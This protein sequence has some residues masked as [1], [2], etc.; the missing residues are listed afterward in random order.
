MFRQFTS[1]E[2]I[3]EYLEHN[4]DA[5]DDANVEQAGEYVTSIFASPITDDPKVMMEVHRWFDLETNTDFGHVVRKHFDDLLE[6]DLNLYKFK[7]LT[8]YRGP[9]DREQFIDDMKD[10]AYSDN[11][12]E[13]VAKHKDFPQEVRDE[14]YKKTE[15]VDF[16][17]QIAQDV[18]IF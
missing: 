5:I 11:E 10:R 13:V 2:Q 16:L 6:T 9:L 15:D 17:P 12:L 8:S 1:K 4:K 3:F 14:L 18:F 7:I